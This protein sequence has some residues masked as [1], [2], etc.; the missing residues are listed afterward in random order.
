MD[1]LYY[2]AAYYDEYMPQDRV[3]RDMELMKA[4]GMNVIRIAEST[5]ATEEP[6][7]GEFDFTHVRRVLEAAQRHG[8]SVIVG[9]PTYAVPP[10][11]AAA[12][13]EVLA[14]TERGAGKYGARQIMDITNPTYLYHAERII[15]RLVECAQEYECVIGFQLDNETKH[16]HT[17]GP[18]VQRRFVRWLRDRFGTVEALN[19]EFGFD[20]WSNRVDCWEDIPDVTGS[21]NASFRAEF[22]KFRRSLVTGFLRWQADI[23]S[24]YLREDQFLT[25]NFDYGW[26]GYSFG[27]Q[28]DVD[29]RAASECL[30][31]TGCDIYHPSQDQLTGKEI[32]FCGDMARS[33]KRQNYLVLE[34]QAQGFPAWTPYDGQLRQQAFSHLASGAEGVMYWHWHS[35]HNACET[36]WKGVLSHDLQ[37]NAPYREC[38]TI[39]ADFSRL[40]PHLAGLKKE[41]KAALLVSNESLTGMEQFPLPGGETEYNDVVRGLYDVLYELNVEC[42]ILFPQDAD[43][44]SQYPMA[45]VPA[46]Y[47]APDSLLERLEEYVKQGGHLVA[48]FKTGFSN[49]FLTVAQERQPHLLT[50]CFG[51]SY[52][53]FA[54]P[55]NTS[56]AGDGFALTAREREVTAWMELL[57]PTT[58]NVLSSYEHPAWGRYAAVTENLYGKGSAAYLG[59]WPTPAYLKAFF[60]RRLARAGLWGAE[61]KAEFPIVVK[62]G[63]NRLNSRIHYY[64]N[65]SGEPRE[66]EYLHGDGVELLTGRPLKAGETLHLEPWGVQIAEEA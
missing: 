22:E 51:V 25:H 37:P 20:Y 41:N 64:F 33:L 42:D 19:R 1:H 17:A 27:V 44:L 48:S 16:Y 10:W 61:Q 59:C 58:A 66:Q 15:R 14:V 35:I 39:G 9:T 8:L 3:D 21:I 43:R 62:S 2:G 40:S 55:R 24:E 32:A 4:A 46:L 47:S 54:E 60:K 23:V 52:D 65:Y 26:R 45:V 34:T 13:P 6:R 7:D 28:P 57:T 5:W 56:L 36:Y 30:S 29:H 38:C 53:Q 12:H 63:R 50:E 11:L 31:V 18:S 49:E